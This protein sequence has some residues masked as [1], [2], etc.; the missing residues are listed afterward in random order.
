MGSM[1]THTAVVGRG[2][3]AARA[4]YKQ[5]P[6]ITTFFFQVEAVKCAT[7]AFMSRV[8]GGDEPGFTTVG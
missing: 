8:C 6:K 3:R 1:G 4:V 5:P 7:C 2:S